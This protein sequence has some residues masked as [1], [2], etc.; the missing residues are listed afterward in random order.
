MRKAAGDLEVTAASE[1][2]PEL[3][4]VA[5][6]AAYS[7]PGQRVA[8][9]P[10]APGPR[11][12]LERVREPAL[13]QPVR[14]PRPAPARAAP[15]ASRS[16]APGD[17]WSQAPDPSAP[18]PFAAAAPARAAGPSSGAGSALQDAAAA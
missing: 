3:W 17:G 12:A 14:A 6:E 13:A 4:S 5:V 9:R 15:S 11:R 8:A 2:S 1:R 7:A 10:P 16:A 18:A